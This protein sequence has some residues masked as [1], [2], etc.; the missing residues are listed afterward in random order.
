MKNPTRTDWTAGPFDHERLDAYQVAKETLR[1]GELIAAKLPRGYANLADQMRRSLLSSM[2]VTAEGAARVG[3]DRKNRF[4]IAKG[5]AGEA[6]ACIEA[7]AMLGLVDPTEA[8][9]VRYLLA[10][11]CAML[12]G[13]AR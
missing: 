6:A 8:A 10:R 5:E 11:Q 3:A 2:T 4:R 1:R 9:E 13:L 12:G 7:T